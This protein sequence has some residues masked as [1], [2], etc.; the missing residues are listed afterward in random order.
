MKMNVVW[1]WW[2]T[3]WKK[4]NCRRQRQRGRH[5][6]NSCRGNWG[7]FESMMELM[8]LEKRVAIMISRNEKKKKNVDQDFF[9]Q[10]V[11]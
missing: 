8:Y 6:K 10:K 11:N 2:K 5:N 9:L 3:I 4:T 7:Y 1:K